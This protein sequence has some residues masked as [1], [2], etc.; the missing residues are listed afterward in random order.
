MKSQ[1]YPYDKFEIITDVFG[2]RF[3]VKEVIFDKKFKLKIYS[4]RPVEEIK[5]ANGFI[6]TA[7]LKAFILS[8]LDMPGKEFTDRLKLTTVG[9]LRRL[10]QDNP[11]K[12]YDTWVSS[13]QINKPRFITFNDARKNPQIL[14]DALGHRYVLLSASITDEGLILP[15]GVLEVDFLNR[16]R[17][18]SSK[19]ILTHEVAKWVEKIRFNKHKRNTIISDIVFYGLCAE[20]GYSLRKIYDGWN[21]FFVQHFD[22]LLNSKT[23]TFFQKYP[24]LNISQEGLTNIKYNIAFVLREAQNSSSVLIPALLEHWEQPNAETRGKVDAVFG[25]KSSM[26]RRA[27]L[28][29]KK[30]KRI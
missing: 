6:V 3:Y 9:R 21:A 28:L 30:A 12:T 26:I 1:G 2:E 18:T 25:R 20:L 15:K 24:E 17:A 23:K 13:K 29:L 14:I 7:E 19:Y 4:G 10:L 27:F 11:F 5:G 22:E 16:K 8:T